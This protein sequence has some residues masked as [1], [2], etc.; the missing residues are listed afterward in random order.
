M[1]KKILLVLTVL[2]I[3][4]GSVVAYNHANRADCPG[5]MTC[6]LTGKIICV[7]QCPSRN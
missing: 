7:D 2:G 4:A 1:R 5:K 6:P 3:G